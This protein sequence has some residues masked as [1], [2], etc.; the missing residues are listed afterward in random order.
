M[1]K[2]GILFILIIISVFSGVIE[3]GEVTGAG[4]QVQTILSNHNFTPQRLQSMGLTVKL[5]E[6][7]GAGRVHV[8]DVRMLVTNKGVYEVDN[9][10]N[11]KFK[12]PSAGK[13]VSEVKS[14]DF[15]TRKLKK[16]QV[17]AYILEK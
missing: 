16:S 5:G 8:D 3:A 1:N 13:F 4:R 2:L 11:I 9:L 17:L 7:T 10:H 14:F 6:V 15:P 12:H